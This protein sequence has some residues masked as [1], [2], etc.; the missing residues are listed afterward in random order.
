MGSVLSKTSTVSKQI[1]DLQKLRQKLRQ[2]IQQTRSLL[3][4]S[5]KTRIRDQLSEYLNLLS[6]VETTI[7]DVEIARRQQ[8]VALQVQ[9]AEELQNN[10]REVVTSIGE[11]VV[12]LNKFD[13]ESLLDVTS[14]DWRELDI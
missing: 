3:S 2:D 7:L 9:A 10:M 12:F 1:R 4:K 13:S 14:I 6:R 5:S 8:E 11:S